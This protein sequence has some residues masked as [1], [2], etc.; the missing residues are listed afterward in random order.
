MDREEIIEKFLQSELDEETMTEFVS[1]LQESKDNIRIFIREAH[2]RKNILNILNA[3][4]PPLDDS[5]CASI[6]GELPMD[7]LELAAGG[8]KN[9]PAE[10]YGFQ[11]KKKEP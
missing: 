1:W 3:Q 5:E 11:R 9:D 2:D 4:A 8:L 6:K 7:Y 10:E